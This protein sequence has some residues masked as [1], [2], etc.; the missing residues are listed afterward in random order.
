MGKKKK[1]LPQPSGYQ[2]VPINPLSKKERVEKG[3]AKAGKSVG[4]YIRA[5]VNARNARRF[6]DN[7]KQA[8]TS[9]EFQGAMSQFF[10]GAN[11]TLSQNM[12]A[13]L[14]PA[15]NFGAMT[16]GNSYFFPDNGEAERRD[17]AIRRARLKKK[18]A[19][20]EALRREKEKPHSFTITLG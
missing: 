4:R 6:G 3:L 20:R 12:P 8:L 1:S 9:N 18:L 13:Y 2:I 10:A 17:A 5:N 15:G 19:K 16:T 14:N 11:S 7:A